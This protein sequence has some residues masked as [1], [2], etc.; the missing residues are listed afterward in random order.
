MTIDDIDVI[1]NARIVDN[2]YIITCR[3]NG[4][5]VVNVFCATPEDV[6]SRIVRALR[7]FNMVPASLADCMYQ[8]PHGD[9]ANDY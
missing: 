2:G 4:K 1:F 8:I 5:R 3:K 6:A 7:E 9:K